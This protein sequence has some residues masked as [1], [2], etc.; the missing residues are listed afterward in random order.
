MEDHEQTE[1]LCAERAEQWSARCCR[2]R[3][4]HERGGSSRGPRP[5]V[6][7]PRELSCTRPPSVLLWIEVTYQNL[8][9]HMGVTECT[10]FRT[11]SSSLRPDGQKTGQWG[12]D[13]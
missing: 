3:K 4:P 8:I 6:Q 12:K 2:G 5:P 13:Q 9:L 11:G 1:T 7:A 10:S